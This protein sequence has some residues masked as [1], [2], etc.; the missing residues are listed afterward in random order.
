METK[1]WNDRLRSSLSRVLVVVGA[2]KEGTIKALCNRTFLPVKDDL[3]PT[4]VTFKFN[5]EWQQ[6]HRN[7]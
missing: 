5:Q 2:S 7:L 3:K 4:R 1:R 6:R